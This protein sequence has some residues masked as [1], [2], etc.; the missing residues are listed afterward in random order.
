MKFRSLT[1]TLIELLVVI[2]I[3]AI[4]ASMLLPALNTARE[5]AKSI[6]CLSNLKQLYSGCSGYTSDYDDFYPKCY[7][8][9]DL[10]SGPGGAIVYSGPGY[11]Q[12]PQSWFMLILNYVGGL[13]VVNKSGGAYGME[14]TIFNCPKANYQS[15][16]SDYSSFLIMKSSKY[17]KSGYGINNYICGWAL[18]SNPY[19]PVKAG[20]IKNTVG[21]LGETY[22]PALSTVS[23]FAVI[24]NSSWL[25]ATE[26]R[27]D[28]G[29]FSN[30][31]FTDGHTSQVA[32]EKC[33]F[34]GASCTSAVV[35]QNSIFY[36]Q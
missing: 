34:P 17:V 2:A 3:I 8:S 27:H 26:A 10:K 11:E 35:K 33:Y 36:W 9:T 5:K 19:S 30:A 22:N 15:M 12:Y 21:L 1:F 16:T 28:G 24:M 32:R 25:T 18:G 14:G 29:R 31:A 13:S 7:S 6:K 20:K 23:N 4:L